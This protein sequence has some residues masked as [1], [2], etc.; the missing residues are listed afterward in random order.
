MRL[1]LEIY[2]AYGMTK[3]L[4]RMPNK[5]IFLVVAVGVLV[6]GAGVVAASYFYTHDKEQQTEQKK[7]IDDERSQLDAA[8]FRGDRDVAAVYLER[9]KD[10]QSDAAYE[11]YQSAVQ[12]LPDDA[13]KIALYEQGI[14]ISIQ[15]KQIDHA[16]RLAVQLSDLSNTH[17]S[18]ANAAYLYGLNKDYENQKKYLQK[19]I[20]QLEQLPKDS[21][22]YI[23]MKAY[24]QD[25]LSKVGVN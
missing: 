17:R 23:D 8:A 22:E 6:L 16:I 20:D 13:S 11:V 24:Y 10:K 4:G 12:K 3:K 14:E 21:A 19:S 18:S 5:R 1:C 25:M 2:Y 7:V 15:A 9:V